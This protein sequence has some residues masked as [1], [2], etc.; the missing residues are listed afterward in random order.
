MVGNS[1]NQPLCILDI[2]INM[3]RY[4]IAYELTSSLIRLI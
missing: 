3:S 2:L 4:P 1:G